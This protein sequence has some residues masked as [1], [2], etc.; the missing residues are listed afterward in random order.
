VRLTD[1][2][3]EKCLKLK[4]ICIPLFS[5]LCFLEDWKNSWRV[6]WTTWTWRRWCTMFH[7]RKFSFLYDSGSN[8]VA[9]YRESSNI[10]N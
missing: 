10:F 5:Y 3:Q 9:L 8:L 6:M 7:E 1:T 2:S 4:T